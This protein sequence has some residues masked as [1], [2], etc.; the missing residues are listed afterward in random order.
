MT[1]PTIRAAP[2]GCHAAQSWSLRVR[3]RAAVALCALALVWQPPAAAQGLPA[4]VLENEYLARLDAWVAGGGDLATVQDDV[5]ANCG[6]LVMLAASAA[7]REAFLGANQQEFELRLEICTG[8]TVNRVHPQ[9]AFEHA[10]LVALICD[11]DNR[12]YT[13]LCARGGLR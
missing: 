13:R 8:I 5:V 3:Q 12:L 11:G 7:E 9:S 6:Q 10:E 2:G 4:L 1:H